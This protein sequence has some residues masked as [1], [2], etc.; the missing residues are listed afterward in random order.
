L[1]I[2]LV[3]THTIHHAQGLTLDRLAFDPTCGTKHGSTYTTLSC[4][5]S[6]EHLYSLS[7]LPNKNVQVNTLVQKEMHQPRTIAQ[8]ELMFISIKSYYAKFVIIK[9][10]NI[11]SL[12]LH[13]QKHSCKTKFISI[14]HTLFE[15]NKN[16]KYSHKP[17]SMQC[18]ITKN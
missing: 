3:G 1:P 7:R 12:T 5:C 14:S 10:L 8:Y 16:T 17:R 6:K 13:F 9:S 15:R 4:I 18:Y 2:Q 11:H